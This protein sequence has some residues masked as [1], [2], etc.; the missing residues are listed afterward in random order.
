MD[1]DTL[2]YLVGD[3]PV[4]DQICAAIRTTAPKDHVH[5]EYATQ[6]E[7]EILRRKLEMLMELVGDTSVADQIYMA[8]NN[9]K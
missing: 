2:Y 7:V 3:T 8:I 9:I 4:C 6:N 5:T 1:K